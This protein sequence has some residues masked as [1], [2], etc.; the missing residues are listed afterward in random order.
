MKHYILFFLLVAMCAAGECQSPNKLIF[1]SLTTEDGLPSNRTT[2]TFKDHKGFVWVACSEG[3]A[4]YD[5]DERFEIFTSSNQSA[6]KSDF[7]TVI[8][9]DQNHNIWIGT[10]Q[11]GVTKYSYTEDIWTNYSFD[12]NDEHSLSH[13]EVLSILVDSNNTVW[14]GTEDGLNIY[15]EETDS[16]WRYQVGSGEYSLKSRAI[17]DIY[18]DDKGHIWLGTWGSGF[19]LVLDNE[20][21]ESLEFRQFG[22]EAELEHIWK[23]IQVSDTEYCLGSYHYGLVYLQAKGELSDVKEDQDWDFVYKKSIVNSNRQDAISSNTVFDIVARGQDLWLATPSGL[24]ILYDYKGQLRTWALDTTGAQHLSYVKEVTDPRSQSSIIDNDIIHLSVDDEGLLWVATA[25]GLSCYSIYNNQ[26][27]NLELVE[28]FYSRPSTENIVVIGDELWLTDGISI[29]SYNIHTGKR[30]TYAEQIQ[31]IIRGKTSSCISTNKQ[32]ALLIAA[33]DGLFVID[34]KNWTHQ[35]Y[36]APAEILRQVTTFFAKTIYVDRQSRYWLGMQTG[37]VIIDPTTGEFSLASAS[38]PDGLTDDSVSDIV[39]DAEGNI[40]VSTYTGLNRV[41]SEYPDLKFQQYMSDTEDSLTIQS[42]RILALHSSK[43]YLLIGSEHGLIL[44][45]YA[46]QK[47]Q[48]HNPEENNSY[49]HTVYNVNDTIVWGSET[50]G[51]Y[52]YNLLDHSVDNFTSTDG[53]QDLTFSVGA[54][55]SDAQGKL[56]FGNVSGVVGLSPRDYLETHSQ[57]KVYVTSAYIIGKDSSRTTSLLKNDN[58]IKLRHNDYYLRLAYVGLNYNQ[59]TST[60]FAHKL[61]GFDEDWVFTDS[62]NYI[63][64]TNLKAGSYTFRAKAKNNEGTW[65][66]LD[67][68]LKIKVVPA[69]WQRLWFWVLMALLFFLSIALVFKMYTQTVRKRNKKLEVLNH[70]LSDEV[71]QR[72]QIAKELQRSEDNLK[73]TNTELMRSNKQLE[74]FAY[75]ASHDL[76]EPLRTIGTFT[77][78]SKRKM[79]SEDKKLT[80]YMDIVKSAVARMHNLVDSILTFSS[81][82]KGSLKLSKVELK[83]IIDGNLLDLKEMISEKGTDVTISPLPALWGDRSQLSMLFQNLIS[84]GVKFNTS[85]SPYLKIYTT[86]ESDNKYFHIVV[87]DN[88]IGINKEYQSR[89]FELFKRLHS[90]SEFEGTGIGLAVCKQIVELHEGKLAIDSEVGQGTKFII[91][92]PRYKDDAL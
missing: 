52:R 62:P 71:R 80:E 85:D 31:K 29:V 17:L 11:G 24:S 87:E 64:Y 20:R 56:Y 3:L 18:E 74:E 66:E 67:E 38:Q 41:I 73:A 75:I 88:G 60:S 47:F 33:D 21:A 35:F 68:P 4:R 54:V 37:L 1:S 84:N 22:L 63:T 91:S 49:I 8:S 36:A 89:I 9:Q 82:G 39:E 30:N 25:G 13:D 34:V 23:I 14:I 6:I 43:D 86:N 7:V 77:E 51:L 32:G 16:F 57:P 27:E 15:N 12:R 90:S 92:L 42:N 81:I 10:K 65:A 5:G 48:L 44:Y 58:T 40:W 55:S 78:L 26:V 59:P 53:I 2:C 28:N 50:E 83:N 76:K 61:E 69:F 19:Y 70:Q 72:T 45:D 46:T 79:K